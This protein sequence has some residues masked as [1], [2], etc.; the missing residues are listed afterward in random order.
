MVPGSALGEVRGICGDSEEEVSVTTGARHILFRVG[1]T[2]LVTRRL[3]GEFLNYRQSI[4]WKSTISLV[5]DVKS[6]ITSINRVALIL[7]ENAKTPLR[8]IAGD[9]VLY[10]SSVTPTGD[11][12]DQCP[13]EG[14]GDDLHIGFN[15]RFMLDALKAVP[16]EKAKLLMG[17]PSTPCIIVP[18]DQE[19]GEEDF[20]F[21]VLP[22]RM[23]ANWDR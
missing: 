15:H 3:E 12:S 9:N 7:Q 5:A 23:S 4:N 1:S 18:T 22:V 14:S 17:T 20:L 13:V 11:A 16:A 6:L 10:L 2:L 19:S 8:C 21:M